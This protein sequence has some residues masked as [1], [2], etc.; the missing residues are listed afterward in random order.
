MNNPWIPT[1][2]TKSDEFKE[3]ALFL[4]TEYPHAFRVLPVEEKPNGDGSWASYDFDGTVKIW[5]NTAHPECLKL[6]QEVLSEKREEV[7]TK[8]LTVQEKKQV[9]GMLSQNF[10]AIRSVLPESMKPE[11]IMR[12]GYQI[13]VKNPELARN[14]TPVSLMNCILE[15]ASLGIEIGGP[16]GLAHIIPNKKKRMAELRLDYKG[17]IELMHRS[18]LV[19]KVVTNAVY[20][21]DF[22]DYEYGSKQFLRHRPATGNKG[23]LIAAY[24]Q[25][26]FE[27]GTDDFVICDQE[28]A[29]YA[30]SKSEAKN[31][32]YSP[33]NKPG[34]VHWMWIKTAVHRMAKRIP[35]SPELQ[36][37]INLNS[38]SDEGREQETTYDHTIDVE[39]SRIAEEVESGNEEQ[40]G[41]IDI[42]PEPE[43]N[44][45]EVELTEDQKTLKQ[46]Y[47]VARQ[48]MAEEFTEACGKLDPP[49]NP[50][51][52]HTFDEMALILK[53]MN[54]LL[55]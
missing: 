7:M 10:N 22:F 20:E 46:N 31:S 44:D 8:E 19:R 49:L 29:E 15:S 23:K 21:N 53:K 33:W 52:K 3:K 32:E 9:Y 1:Q 47:D 34:E 36:R 39:F 30:K 26:F 42:T 55:G 17:E 54:E 18:P 14:C 27:N 28:M 48:T 6:Y 41:A 50:D 38:A 16:L 24:C 4:S 40:S 25:V 12:L 2:I 35:K 13:V 37:A 43:S 45:P 51:A 11:K 5:A